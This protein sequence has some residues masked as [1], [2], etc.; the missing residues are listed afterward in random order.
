[1]VLKIYSVYDTKVE[2]YLQPF[3]MQ[4][5]AAAIRAWA[6]AI[7]DPNTQF[8]KH[9]NDF[10]LYELGQYDDQSGIITNYDVKIHLGNASEYK[11]TS[12]SVTEQFTPLKRE[13]K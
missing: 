10:T 6:D 1:M 7:S 2:A 13:Q 8:N 4:T 12:E 9:P 5:K 3:F 11:N